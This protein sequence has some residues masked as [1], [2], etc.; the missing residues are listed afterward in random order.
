[1]PLTQK[2]GFLAIL[3]NPRQP[4]RKSL[5]LFKGSGDSES[6]IK[7]D[8]FEGLQPFSDQNIP[9]NDMKSLRYFIVSSKNQFELPIKSKNVVQKPFKKARKNS[10]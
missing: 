4:L 9:S 8:L 7:F 1:M 2:T 3:L 10:K 5:P 6:A